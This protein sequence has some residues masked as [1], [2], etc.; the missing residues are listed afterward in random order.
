M[1]PSRD[2][3]P[4]R[5]PPKDAPDAGAEKT[6]KKKRG[7]QP[8]ARGARM[9]WNDHP[10]ETV[11]H[12]PSGGCRCGADLADA[13]DLGVV[14]SHQ[15]VEIPPVSATTTQHDLHAVRCACGKVH[16]ADRP[17]GVG[18]GRTGYGPLYR[19]RYNGPYTERQIIPRARR[20]PFW[21]VVSGLPGRHNHC[22][23]HSGGSPARPA[24]P[25][26]PGRLASIP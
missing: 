10:D 16:T 18:P 15:Q 4:G 23:V 3:E 6:K 12:R 1:R 2:D 8:G 21:C 25:P 22:L 20:R 7:K 17:E 11:P 14:A 13:A 26:P 19:I 5:T 9:E 24:V